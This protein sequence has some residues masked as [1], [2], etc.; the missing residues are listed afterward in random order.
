[1]NE[2]KYTME[3]AKLIYEIVPKLLDDNVT[4]LYLDFPSKKQAYDEQNAQEIKASQVKQVQLIGTHLMPDSDNLKPPYIKFNDQEVQVFSEI[5]A[6]IVTE[7]ILCYNV[8]VVIITMESN[9][10]RYHSVS[11]STK[12]KHN[13]ISKFNMDEFVQGEYQVLVL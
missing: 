9:N 6:D 4:V 11:S 13:L 8:S 10:L 7:W 2:T 12:K 1:M 5:P 3:A